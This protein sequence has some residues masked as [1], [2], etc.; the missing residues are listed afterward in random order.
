MHSKEVTYDEIYSDEF[1]MFM[2]D[3]F[4][5]RQ[6]AQELRKFINDDDFFIK[7]LIGYCRRADEYR[8]CDITKTITTLLQIAKTIKENNK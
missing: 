4:S 1:N 7:L 5:F 2:W 3:L 6:E 8:G